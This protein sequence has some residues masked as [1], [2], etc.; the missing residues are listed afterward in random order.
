MLPDALGPMLDR[1]V[2]AIREKTFGKN[3]P[4]EQP[5]QQSAYELAHATL[6]QQRPPP[7]CGLGEAPFLVAES[8]PGNLAKSRTRLAR[9]GAKL[10]FDGG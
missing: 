8:D 9:P 1:I 7:I 4:Y 2:D 3:Q 10:A 6:P 5:D